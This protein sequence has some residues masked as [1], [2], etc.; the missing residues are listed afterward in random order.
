M[1]T[2]L[3]AIILLCVVGLSF[4]ESFDEIQQ[5]ALEGDA[6]AQYNLGA[7]YSTGDGVEQDNKQ[8]FYW[9]KKSAE[10][11]DLY[12]E[13]SLGVMYYFGEGTLANKEQAL[14]WLQRAADGGLE[15][16]QALLKQLPA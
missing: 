5:Y 15:E 14:S 3:K 1:R 4:G 10:Q 2:V 11:G 12:A 7:L 9:F 6:Q 16:A 13:Y 8:A